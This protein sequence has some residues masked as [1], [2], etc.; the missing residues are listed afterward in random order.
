MSAVTRA[1]Q[2]DDDAVALGKLVG[3]EVYDVVHLAPRQLQR[4]H[5]SQPSQ[6]RASASCLYQQQLPA[7]QVMNL[8]CVIE[9]DRIEMA[10]W[11]H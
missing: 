5:A 11:M 6:V 1:L 3:G 4:R 9:Q 10:A 8:Q 7:D 2:P